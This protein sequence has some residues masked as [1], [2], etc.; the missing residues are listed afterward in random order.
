MRFR[1]YWL[2]LFSLIPTISLAE[3]FTSSNFTLLDPVI[4]V[5]AGRSS[6]AGFEYYSSTGQTAIG[7]SSTGSFVYRSG[8]LYFPSV[9]TPIVFSNAGNTQVTLS[10]TPAVA[11]DLGFVVGGYQ[12]GQS[13]VSGGPYSFTNVGLVLASNR[14][15]LSNNTTYYFVVRALDS[16]GNSIVTSTQVSATPVGTTPG[17]GGGGG[18]GGGIPTSNTSVT[19]YG[20]AY[21]NSTVTLLKDAQLAA[22]T[23]SGPD[24]RFQI[25]LA[26]L[27]AGSFI[28]SLYSDDLNGNRSS[29]LSFPITLTTGASATVSGIFLSPTIAVD[30]GQVKKGETIAI[31]GQSAPETQITISVHSNEEMFVQTNSDE[32]G[33]YLYNFD[34]TPLEYGQHSTKSRATLNT[35]VSA[36]GKSASFAVGTENTPVDA[37]CGRADLNCDGRVNLVDFSILAYWYRR[38]PSEAFIELERKYLNGDAA[39]T[40]ADFSIMAFYWTG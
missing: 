4:V 23:V 16:F 15:G 40:L 17:G 11:D 13:T 12:I 18:G 26:D 32:D 34:T 21:P 7:E 30:K 9:T 19:F 3:A 33:V 29:L 35:E 5:E 24:A 22:T 6:S 25:T 10:W 38:T 1:F 14:T 37:I 28:F 31:F 20:R 39:V 8:F 2:L 27:S 36:F